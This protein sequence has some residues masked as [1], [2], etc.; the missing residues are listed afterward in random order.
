MRRV[1]TEEAYSGEVPLD[2][3]QGHT[4]RE[5]KYLDKGLQIVLD[6][7][8]ALCIS[9]REEIRICTGYVLSKAR[10]VL[11]ERGYNVFQAKIAG[12]T[13]VLAEKEFI[14]SLTRL[15]V[16]NNETVAGMRNFNGFLDWVKAEI[17]TRERFVKTGWSSWPKLKSGENK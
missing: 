17:S 13:Q 8:R 6:G 3:F 7:V 5:K 1:E 12:G 14:K 9:P 2:L 10:E 15:G 4:F 16:G 11:R